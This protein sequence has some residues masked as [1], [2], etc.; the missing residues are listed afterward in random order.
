MRKIL[1]PKNNAFFGDFAG[2]A[3]SKSLFLAYYEGFCA[4]K[5][6]DVKIGKAKMSKKWY[7]IWKNGYFLSKNYKKRVLF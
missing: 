1:L 4:R 3:E 5:S 6:A 7:E 2:C